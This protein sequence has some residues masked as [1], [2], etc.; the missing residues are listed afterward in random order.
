MNYDVFFSI[1][2]TPIDG[3]EPT[4]KEML[5]NFFDQVSLADSLG[6]KTAWIA[7]AHL[8]TQVQKQNKNP[9]VPHWKGEIGLCTD[10]FQLAHH[11]FSRTNKIEVGSAV[12]SILCNGGPI[13]VAER[14]ANFCTLHGMRPDETR[15]LHIGFSAS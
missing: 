14:I 2:Q 7:Q 13:G 3:Y 10:F 5:Q 11:V 15:K 12:L 6:Y 1:S 4:E 9:V 8:S